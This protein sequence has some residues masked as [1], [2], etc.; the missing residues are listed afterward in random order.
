MLGLQGFRDACQVAAGVN[1]PLLEML[2]DAAQW[3]DK[4]AIELFREGAPL[5]GLLEKSGVGVEVPVADDADP[6]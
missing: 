1:G 6:S 2:A 5:F 3:H 4:A